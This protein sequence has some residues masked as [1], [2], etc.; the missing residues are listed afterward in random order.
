MRVTD[1]VTF[2]RILIKQWNAFY[3]QLFFNLEH[4]AKEDRKNEKRKEEIF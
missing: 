4:V 3:T 1:V 2:D